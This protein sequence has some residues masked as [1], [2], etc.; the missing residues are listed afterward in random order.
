MKKNRMMRLS[1]I[2]LVFVLLTSCVI[3]GTFA[4]YTTEKELTS[5][6]RVAVWSIDFAGEDNTKTDFVFDLFAT[7]KDTAG[8]D[9]E[10]V[11]LDGT[12]SESVIAPGTSGSFDIVLV[13]NSEVDAEYSYE[14]K[15]VKTTNLPIE[16]KVTGS[17]EWVTDLASLSST[18]TTALEMGDEA[19]I[20][21]DWRWVFEITGTDSEIATQNKADTGF[22]ETGGNISVT[23]TVLVEQVD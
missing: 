13:N 1:S 7:I 8:A 2:L 9:E 5:S 14:F 16:F 4:K 6:A 12:G 10:D 11:D 20:T 21:V 22:G 18:A 19:T 23:A 15:V 3:S 17:D